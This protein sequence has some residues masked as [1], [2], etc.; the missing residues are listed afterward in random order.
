MITGVTL[1]VTSGMMQA[2]LD[3]LTESGGENRAPAPVVHYIAVFARDSFTV[4]FEP[5]GALDAEGK[6]DVTGEMPPQKFHDPKSAEQPI[7]LRKNEFKRLGYVFTGWAEYPTRE[8][9]QGRSYDDEASFAEVTIYQ[10][11]QIKDGDK[12]T[13]Y[14][15]WERLPDVTIFYTP[16]PTSLGTVKLNGTAAKE[17]DPITVQEGTVYESLNPETG[18]ARGATA[19]PGEGS[20]FVGWYDAQDTERKD[21]LTDSRSEERR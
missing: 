14:A 3:S 7:K 5:N 13:L 16:E 21:P 4:Q 19:V 15:Q 20:V 11:K 17:N 12:I 18:T 2:K 8:D 1:T 9:G 6:S 10:K